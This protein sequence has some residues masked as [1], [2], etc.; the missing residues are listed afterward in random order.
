M[1]TRRE[2]TAIRRRIPNKPRRFTQRFIASQFNERNEYRNTVRMLQRNVGLASSLRFP[3]DVPAPIRVGNIVTAYNRKYRVIH[4]GV[5]LSYDERSAR[6]LVQF[7]RKEFGHDFCP[8]S[9]VAS[10]GISELLFRA[11][12]RTLAA[13]VTGVAGDANNATENL[14]CTSTFGSIPGKNMSI[15]ISI[16]CTRPY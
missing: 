8:D 1:L 16:C 13:S 10:H 6:Y 2:W 3:Y 5:V 12:E 14:P 9:E 11:P 15:L 7:E 4:R